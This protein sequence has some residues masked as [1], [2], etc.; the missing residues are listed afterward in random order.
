MKSSRLIKTMG[1]ALII[2]FL[3]FS[4]N[5]EQTSQNKNKGNLVL[6]ADA[7]IDMM[8]DTR[9][10][11]LV[12]ENTIVSLKEASSENLPEKKELMNSLNLI[13][14]F[15]RKEHLDIEKTI[16]AIKYVENYSKRYKKHILSKKQIEKIKDIIYMMTAYKIY[17]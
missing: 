3:T 15:L 1:I 7:R 17:G 2:P 16:K 9:E 12:I 8:Q 4:C 6:Y 13:N 11:K 5:S 14:G 10:L